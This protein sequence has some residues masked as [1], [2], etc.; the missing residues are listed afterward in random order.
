MLCFVNFGRKI[1][2]RFLHILELVKKVLVA[3]WPPLR[4]TLLPSGKTDE[5]IFYLLDKKTL[6]EYMVVIKQA[7]YF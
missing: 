4:K 6:C 1:A 2:Y 7:I 3:V 5:S